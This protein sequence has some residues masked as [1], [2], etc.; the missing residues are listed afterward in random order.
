MFTVRHRSTARYCTVPVLNGTIP[1][2]FKPKVGNVFR[3]PSQCR[4]HT[5]QTRHLCVKPS[6]ARLPCCGYQMCIE[7]YTLYQRLVT[8]HNP[9]LLN[10]NCD[11]SEICSLLVVDLP[12]YV[13]VCMCLSVC[14]CMCMCE[15][16]CVCVCMY[17]FIYVSVC[18]CLCACVCV[19]VFVCGCL[20]VFVCMCMCVHKCLCVCF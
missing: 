20:Y 16:V 15:C 2:P 3:M 12:M 7:M 17:V 5:L 8:L 9:S 13:C 19:C 6:V 1:G 18:V 14:V 10:L 11:S 4:P